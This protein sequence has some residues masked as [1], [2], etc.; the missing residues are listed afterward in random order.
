MSLKMILLV[1]LIVNN[2][3]GFKHDEQILLEALCSRLEESDRDVCKVQK[4][5]SHDAAIAYIKV[6]Y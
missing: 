3:A 1:V 6:I 2:Y 4:R 5:V